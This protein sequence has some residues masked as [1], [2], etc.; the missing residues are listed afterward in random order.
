MEHD[1]ATRDEFN[2]HP[3]A[4]KIIQLLT[5]DI[6]V[7]PMII[8][9]VWGS[10]KTEFTLKLIS[11]FKGAHPSFK[12]V[13]LDAFRAEHS[14]NPILSLLSEVI[15]SLPEAE[16]PST[17]KK[18]A[19]TLTV[20]GKTLG[21]AAVSWA[22]KQDTTDIVEDYDEQ[23]KQ[24]SDSVIDYS[25]EKLLE[26]F[27]KE[28]EDLHALQSILS[29]LTQDKPLV[30]FI[31]ELD[32]CRPDYAV[33]ML[34]SIKHV[35][36]I[37]NLQ[38][39]LVTNTSQLK[40]TINHTYGVGVDA[41]RYLDKFIA[42][43]VTLPTQVKTNYELEDNSVKHFKNL[44]AESDILNQS[45]LAK[46]DHGHIGTLCDLIKTHERSLREVETLVRYL[47]VYHILSKG[48]DEDIIFGYSLFRVIG[49][50]IYTFEPKIA[51]AIVSERVDGK[52]LLSFFGFESF[53]DFEKYETEDA[54]AHVIIVMRM[55]GR[56]CSTNFEQFIIDD[57]VAM[58][59]FA[60]MKRCYFRNSRRA[61]DRIFSIV[62][63]AINEL[64]MFKA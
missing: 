34:E 32:R 24:V 59:D 45:T 44:I 56:E 4:E 58:Q 8:D 11:L 48:L 53:E 12:C 61:P 39:V 41:Q 57:E 29:E 63:S 50:Y 36:D 46:L 62:E 17:I 14:N 6:S 7:S 49:V 18:I 13:Y 22:L 43:K 3:V 54:Q 55:L 9:G 38:F 60:D 20:I 25:T 47:E 27:V 37:Q 31:D 19:P 42:F 1:F 64:K 40:A 2:R 51:D 21:K 26:S 5:S 15:K 23:I 16:Q 52:V 30:I 10:G 33:S 28:E 35:F